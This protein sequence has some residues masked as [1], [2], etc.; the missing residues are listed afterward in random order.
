MF[1][2]LI[3][4]I[5]VTSCQTSHVVRENRSN[6][7]MSGDFTVPS[8][9]Y[10][11]FLLLLTC[12]V[13]CRGGQRAEVRHEK[14]YS[15]TQRGLKPGNGN[16][17][18]ALAT[19]LNLFN[20]FGCLN[21]ALEKCGSESEI[22]SFEPLTMSSGGWRAPGRIACNIDQDAIV[23]PFEPNAKIKETTASFGEPYESFIPVRNDVPC[24]APIVIKKC[25]GDCLTN[26]KTADASKADQWVQTLAAEPLA[27]STQEVCGDAIV[28]KLNGR[29]LSAD[30]VNYYCRVYARTAITDKI[31]LACAAFRFEVDCAAVID[32]LLD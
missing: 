25:F 19:D 16:F 20:E 13:E 21:M 23:S 5:L 3:V 12:A 1:R 18:G 22:Q 6:P 15:A 24:R 31:P 30:V 14:V 10:P 9:N 8:V 2:L 4:F 27:T 29:K 28:D 7:A 26:P 17:A 11:P 32:S